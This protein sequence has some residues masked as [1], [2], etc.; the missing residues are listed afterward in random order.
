MPKLVCMVQKPRHRAPKL[1]SRSLKL[2]HH[3]LKLLR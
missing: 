1:L 2:L 3:T